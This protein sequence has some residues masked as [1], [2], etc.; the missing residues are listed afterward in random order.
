M[1]VYESENIRNI[2]LVGNKGVGKTSFLDAV[3]FHAG[4]NSRIGRVDD[5]SSLVD[6]DPMEIKRKQS[7]TA[8]VVPVEWKN[9]KINFIDTPG[10]AD[11]L[12]EAICGIGAA[13]IVVVVLDPDRGIE[14]P[15]KRL[16][17]IAVSYNKPIAFLLNGYD[18]EHAELD[19]CV[20]SIRESLNTKAIYLQAPIGAH[21]TFNGVVDLL[22]GKAFISEGGKTKEVAI[23]ADM[24]DVVSKQRTEIIEAVAENDEA[25]LE[26]YLGGGDIGENEIKSGL[27]NG[28]VSGNIRPIF[29]DSATK[30]VGIESFLDM[31]VQWFPAPALLQAPMGTNPDTHQ[32]EQRKSDKSAPLSA[33]VF[34]TTSDPGIGDI[35][36]FRVYSGSVSHG[37]DVYN[38]GKRTAER[39]GHIFIMRGN[40]RDEVPSVMCG[41][42]AAVAKL[43][44][45][46]IGDTLAP[47]NAPIAYHFIKYPEPMVSLAVKPKTK[48][49]QDKLGGAFSKLTA[50][51]PTFKLHIDHEFNETIVAGLGEVHLEVQLERLHE[52]FG[53]EI[54]VGKPRIPY[55]ETIRKTVKVQGKYKK[56]SGGRGQYGDCWIELSP[57]PA[58]S[59][60]EFVDDIVGG[61]IPNRYIPAVEKGIRETMKKGIMSGCPVVDIKAS[62]YDGSYHDVD[63]SDLA[64][65]IAASM[66]F[67]KAEEEANPILLEPVMNVEITVPSQ[68]MGD[69]SSDV[70]GRR[71]RV[72][73]VEHMGDVCTVK[74]QIPLAELYKYSTTIRS[75]TAGAGS[76]TMSFS[77]YDQVPQHI[78]QKIVEETKKNRAEEHEL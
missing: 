18:S 48:Q 65:Q 50:L 1:R 68:Y 39:M 63:S 76:H 5:G 75:M 40:K 19:K 23:P 30:D 10:Y 12:G 41:D 20:A 25:L 28:I 14:I 26:K 7:L 15:A 33:W 72:S 64:F 17:N 2:A 51:D 66:A 70:S 29:I 57:L 42:I 44:S 47:K 8:K 21:S 73:G 37:D 27:V 6:Y 56:Q 77:H 34:K 24:N 55:R 61:S 38:V 9:C 60:F 11:F 16:Y 52:R 35:S 36:F 49:D 67:K 31:A 78:T 22:Q 69:I 59:G 71:G 54:E 53:I 43:K 58:G 4:Q 45:T 3:L 62:L 74:T 46:G 32:E 13:D